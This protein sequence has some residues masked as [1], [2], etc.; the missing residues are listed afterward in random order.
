MTHFSDTPLVILGP[1]SSALTTGLGQKLYRKMLALCTYPEIILEVTCS[2][3]TTT[4]WRRAAWSVWDFMQSEWN[5]IFLRCWSIT[6]PLLINILN[7]WNDGGRYPLINLNVT[8]L[9]VVKKN[10]YTFWNVSFDFLLEVCL[11]KSLVNY[12]VNVHLNISSLSAYSFG[13]FLIF[14]PLPFTW[15]G[16]LQTIIWFS[17][18][19]NLH[20]ALKKLSRFYLQ[21]FF[22]P[23]GCIHC[24]FFFR[25]LGSL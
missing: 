12:K 18:L 5:F 4:K 22:F 13:L 15:D 1:R 24:F 17:N 23:L 25:D 9:H 10:R 19:W 2:D 14:I 6:D 21:Y 11:S 8:K 20:K 16:K 3:S 7:K